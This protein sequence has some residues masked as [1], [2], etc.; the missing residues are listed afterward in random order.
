MNDYE[1]FL[2]KAMKF[3]STKEVCF[4]DLRKKLIE[5]KANET[6]F[7]NIFLNLINEKF[8]NEERYTQS[9]VNDKL[10]F[11]NWGRN[12]I[13]FELQKKQISNILINNVLQNINDDL[14]NS[15]IE[16]LI[17]AKHKEIKSKEKKIIL[18]KISNFLISRGFE[19]SIFL[20]K[21]KLFLSKN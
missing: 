18:T 12:K 19:M 8:I 16:K 14:Y 9:F 2:S 5:W 6:F 13:R 7:E 4:S 1:Y 17:K 21:I 3:C 20:P 15:I 10:N 11:N